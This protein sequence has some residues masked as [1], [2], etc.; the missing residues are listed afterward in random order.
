MPMKMCRLVLGLLDLKLNTSM[1]ATC[2]VGRPQVRVV[3][4]SKNIY[5]LVCVGDIFEF[6]CEM[7]LVNEYMNFALIFLSS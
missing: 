1:N 2:S 4:Q 5:F 3:R 6:C 7:E